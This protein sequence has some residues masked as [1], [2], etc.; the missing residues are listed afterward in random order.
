MTL[1]A[2]TIVA[3]FPIGADRV[4]RP[5]ESLLLVLRLELG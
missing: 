1:S 5:Y 2:L 3:S 4:V